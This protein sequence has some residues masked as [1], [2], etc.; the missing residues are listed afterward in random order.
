M[1]SGPTRRGF[2]RRWTVDET[3]SGCFTDFASQWLPDAKTLSHGMGIK[4][5]LTFGFVQF[6]GALT[7]Q[8]LN[9]Q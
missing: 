7:M 6:A 1:T 2:T 4:K 5:A 3:P 8:T 9:L